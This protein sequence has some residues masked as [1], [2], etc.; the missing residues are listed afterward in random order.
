MSPKGVSEGVLPLDCAVQTYEWGRIGTNSAVA[1]L[2]ANF[3][4]FKADPNTP[5]AELWMGTHAKGAA[6]LK[7]TSTL[8]ADWLQDNQWALGSGVPGRFGKE[9][10]F[11]LKVLSINKA[12]SIQAHPDKKLAE[13][14]HAA[15]PKNY[16][17]KNHKPEMCIALTPFEGLMG[18][19]PLTELSGFLSSVPELRALV[20]EEAASAL[21]SFVANNPEKAKAGGSDPTARSVLQGVYRQLLSADR[22]LVT[23]NLTKL[24]DRLGIN[25]EGSANQLAVRLHRDYPGDVGVFCAYVLNYVS[26]SEGQAMFMAANE[27]HAYLQGECVECMACSDNVVRAGLTPKFKDV[28]N[29][30][31]MLTYQYGPADDRILP[32]QT[33]PK[34]PVMQIFDP[35]I[36]EFTLGRASLR[37]HQTYDMPAVD[38]PSLVLAVEGEGRVD[39][40]DIKVGKGSVL[41]VGAGVAAPITAGSSN[42]LLFRAFCVV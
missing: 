35:P 14:L 29:L 13:Q 5:Y 33:D 12:L 34:D 9:L 30:V 41:F 37:P 11:L 25:P 16:P 31:S 10:P 36:P 18:F 6:K 17:D 15:D 40:T 2:A 1:Q 21:Q 28:P 19:R 26:L 42:L 27:P 38:G 22:G 23:S 24:M 20:G 32:G 4:G 39:G 3:T 7:G 8:L